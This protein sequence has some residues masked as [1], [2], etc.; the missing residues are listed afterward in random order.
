MERLKKMAELLTRETAQF[1][2]PKPYPPQPKDV[3]RLLLIAQ[4]EAL[5]IAAD[6]PHGKCKTEA[7]RLRKEAE[8]AS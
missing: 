2:W 8:H 6:L 3:A 5:E 4:A 1:R 7:A